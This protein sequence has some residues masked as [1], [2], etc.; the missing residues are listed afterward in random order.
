MLSKLLNESSLS[1]SDLK[2]LFKVHFLNP[3]L[4][5]KLL[6]SNEDTLVSID[7][8]DDEEV[9]SEETK[10]STEAIISSKSSEGFELKEDI[11]VYS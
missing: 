8:S 1:I 10:Q 3:D 11:S 2:T 6:K 9:N 7:R 5:N 4:Q